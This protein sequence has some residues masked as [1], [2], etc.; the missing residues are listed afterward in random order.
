MDYEKL[1]LTKLEHKILKLLSIQKANIDQIY[2][3]FK[4]R[5]EQITYQ[6]T[7]QGLERKNLITKSDFGLSNRYTLTNEGS[8]YLFFLKKLKLKS[9]KKLF[10]IIVSTIVTTLVTMWFPKI[11]NK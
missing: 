9:I 5:G 4:F 7:V 8:N 3:Y 2:G 6:A 10:F 1:M 11:L